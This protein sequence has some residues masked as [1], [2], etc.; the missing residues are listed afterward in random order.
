MNKRQKEVLQITLNDEEAVL[1]ALESNYTKALADIKRNIKELQANPL[2][3]SKAY[4]L[5]F[6]KQLEAQVSGIL[7]NLQG[8]NFTSVADYLQKSYTNGFI[9]NMYDMQGQGVP[10]VIPIDESQVLMA[11]QKT[12]DD[13]KLSNKR[14]ISTKKL[15]KQVHSELIR[16]LATELSYADIARNISE[17][18]LADM[19][20]ATTIARTEGHRVQTQA[21]LDS[22]QKAKKLGADV[23]KQWDCTLDGK[24]RPEHSQLDGQ[25]RELDEMFETSGYSGSAPGQFG[26]P[27][28]DCNCRCCLLQRARWAVKGETSYQKWNNETGGF[29]ECTGYEDFKQKY[30]K[31]SEKLKTS[32]TSGIIS[33]SDCKDFDSLSAYVQKIYEFDIDDSVKILDY[34]TVQQSMI[35]IEKVINEFPQAKQTLTGIGTSKNGVMCAGYN[36]KINFNPAYY[37]DGKPSVAACMVQGDTTGFHPKNTGV[38]ETGSHEMGHLLERTLIE[39]SVNDGKYPFGA[40]AWNDSTESKAI[41]S[42]ACKTVKKTPEGKGFRNAQLK[43]QVS[44]YATKNDSECLAECVADYVANGDGAS[45]LSKEVW[46]MLKER[47]G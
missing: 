18:G 25:I 4:Q 10:L 33:I 7:D 9:G 43:S 47:L 32:Q 8:R 11:V 15:K 28:M 37:A 14:G 35:G 5:E 6:Q 40:F 42:Q 19:N 24:T 1:N 17:Y 12:G 22:M 30:L 39:K 31:A 16:G 26:D 38:L 20:R 3:Q 44:G 46:K 13:F 41:I 36:G 29:I 23:V 34:A 27:Y 21:R 45:I 2:T